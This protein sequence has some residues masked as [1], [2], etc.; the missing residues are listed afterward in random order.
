ME[1]EFFKPETVARIRAKELVED[2]RVTSDIAKLD[3]C[4]YLILEETPIPGDFGSARKF[5]KHGPEVKPRRYHTLEQAIREALTPIQLRADAF[6]KLDSEMIYCGYSFMPLGRDRRKRKVALI[7]C[8]EG[9]RLFAYAHQ[10]GEEIKIKAYD[11]SRKV[12]REGA[13]AVFEVPS[14][15]EGEDFHQ[16]KLM[17]IPVVDSPEKFAI[18]LNF[19]SDH[20]C[21]AKRFNIR[22]RYSDDK[23]GSGIVNVCSHEVAAYLRAIEY[24]KNKHNLVP[25]QMCQFALPS[26]KTVDF[27]K[28]LGNNVL[29]RDSARK[30]NGGLRHLNRAEKEIALWS[31][32]EELGHDRTFYSKKSRDGNLAEYDWSS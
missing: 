22:Y 8:L 9:A 5:M 29:V 30:T 7:E 11:R 1:K 23:E 16:F 31:L 4:Q 2:V 27:Y 15:T 21:G 32:V 19:G 20:S 3:S 17:S 18:S 14:R 6:D 26:Q 25:L 28:A 13:E 12:R 24:Y 10:T